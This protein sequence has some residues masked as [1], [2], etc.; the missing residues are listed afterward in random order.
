MKTLVILLFLSLIALTIA[1]CI[2]S[3][4]L[5]RVN[6]DGSGEV[7]E[8]FLIKTDV[9]NML[10]GFV[11]TPGDKNEKTRDPVD[12]EKLERKAFAMGEGVSLKSAEE[13]T[14]ED[15][16]GYRAVFGFADINKL[17]VN[18][19]PD[20][21]VPAVDASEGDAPETE[22]ITFQF[23]KG[24]DSEPALL[25]IFNPQKEPEDT[26]PVG[27]GEKREISEAADEEMIEMLKEIF[28]GMRIH[29]AV[30]VNGTILSTDAAYREGSKVTLIDM[31][32]TK[33]IENEELFREL[34]A[35]DTESIEKTKEII[36]DI[37]GI[38]VELQDQVEIQFQ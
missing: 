12:M 24:T 19:N 14:S 30:E 38:R 29:L 28:R 27:L 31:D 2:E 13:L 8:T 36:K 7:E 10:M 4:T 6:R 37:P 1:G 35:K 11:E 22:Y 25:T 15:G 32:F 9:L 5:I 21:N 23:R 16:Q 20:E 18:E 33:I 26:T 17:V 34:A 3:T